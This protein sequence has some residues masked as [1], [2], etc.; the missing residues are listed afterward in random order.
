MTRRTSRR[1]PGAL[2]RSWLAAVPVAVVLAGCSRTAGPAPSSGGSTTAAVAPAAAPSSS[3]TV[4]GVGVVAEVNG[5]PILASELDQKL[6]ARLGR[7]RQEEYEIRR[8]ALDELIGERLVA[9]EAA[10]RGTTTEEL[11][12]KEVDAKAA[13]MSDAQIETIYE[14][15]K[16]RFGGQARAD[17]LARIRDA[18]VGRAKA[19]RRAAFEKELR[20]AARVAVRL[21]APRASVDIP[22]NA[23]S[24]GAANAPVT[25]VE[26]T[27]YQCPYC[28]RA[29]G[30]IDEVL[31]RYS[32][33]VRLVHL[34]F[35]LDGHPGAI[36][37]ARA[38][39]CAGE[40]GRFWEYHR[41]LMTTN[42]ALD[43]AD[44]KGRAASLQ[45]S[46]P[47]FA[48]C[49]SSGRFDAAIQASVRQGEGLGVTGTPAYFV[50]GWMI[51]GAR[52]VESFAEVIDAQLAGR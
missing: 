19:E 5:A 1:L 39:R 17:A 20:D 44:L 18:V 22:A 50:N 21:D 33:K 51:S 35:P 41:N 4:S 12:R 47:S 40:Q 14:Q 7:L 9:A 48:S 49:L 15:N 26:F 10:K 11:L 38:A 3:P 8:Q 52:P 29:Q 43:D 37:A 2:T 46:A 30:V 23:P 25:I 45:L 13:P 34:D 32:G 16:A 6:G 31:Q 24:T 36:P 42:G 28:H 27:D